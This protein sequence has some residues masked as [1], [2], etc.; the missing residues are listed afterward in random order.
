MVRKTIISALI[1]AGVLLAPL[2][3]DAVGLGK[4]TVSSG[5]GQP[6]RGEMELLAVDRAEEGSLSARLASQDVFREAK[7]ERTAALI[8][9]R[10]NIEQK[11]NGA[12]IIKLTSPQ[13]INDPFL[14]MLIEVNWPSG[15]LLREYTVLL[16]PPGVMAEQQSVMAVET[17]ASK[18]LPDEM[19]KATLPQSEKPRTK[20]ASPASAKAKPAEESGSDS[21]GPVKAGQSL[22]KIAS[23][24]KPEGV[25][26]EQMLVSLYRANQQAFSGNNMNRLK[27]GQ[28][29][30][31]PESSQVAA[32]DKGE[33]EREIRAH[34][35]DWHAYRQKLAGAVETAKPAHEDQ[36][37][38]TATGKITSAVENAPG[39]KEPAKDV[40]KLSKSEN[41]GDKPGKTVATEDAIARDK[42]LQ[43]ANQR[44]AE[45]DKNIKDMQRLLEIRNQSMADL[46]KQA[47]P[48]PP[49]PA[50]AEEKKT[51][52]KPAP[53]K[54]P[55]PAPASVPEQATEQVKP[56]P[57]IVT[58]QPK[59]PETPPPSLL[60]ELLGNPLA[61]IGGALALLLGGLFGARNIIARRKSGKAD[62][63]ARGEAVALQ[64]GNMPEHTL[65]EVSSAL[66]DFTQSGLGGIDTNEVDPIAEAEVY[67]A[68]GRDV[69]AEEILREALARDPQRHEI[70]L[71]LLEIYAGRKD[72][73]SFEALA[74][75]LYAATG[76]SPD[77]DWDKAAE[78]GR[79]LDAANPLYG[80]S[81][82]PPA[83]EAPTSMEETLGVPIDLGETLEAVDASP[84]LDFNLDIASEPLESQMDI[85][86]ESNAASSSSPD[87]ETVEEL[88]PDLDFDLGLDAETPQTEEVA[89]SAEIS[90]ADENLLDFN[91]ETP[92]P[93][94]MLPEAAPLT[95]QE[96][97]PAAEN[98]P[99]DEDEFVLNFD[100]ELPDM[101]PEAEAETVA[102]LAE[103]PVAEEDELGSTAPEVPAATVEMLDFPISELSEST[104]PEMPV[105]AAEE[106]LPAPSD[107]S[108]DETML[109]DLSDLAQDESVAPEATQAPTPEPALPHEEI[110]LTP[111]AMSDEAMLDFDFDIGEETPP[112]I[113]PNLDLSGIDLHLAAPASSDETVAKLNQEDT[114]RFQDAATKMDLAK[115]YMEMGDKEGASEILQE[116]LQEGSDEQQGDAQKLLNE[117]G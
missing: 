46:Q 90:H 21:Y 85:A 102:E 10:F 5:L 79:M 47:K 50:A 65:P 20:S 77:R 83:A 108:F 73:G 71:K 109:L 95:E 92:E 14:D 88:A 13:P 107:T 58:L 87:E 19:V 100:L 11:K 37:R 62:E 9:L 68:Y 3:A 35:A 23:E 38:Q 116:V 84:D 52:T 93:T 67:M 43:D 115:A 113:T 104:A 8:T 114:A 1:G 112:P 17:P 55:E 69:Q 111:P 25:S 26:L 29:L 75:Q 76:G 105:P 40:L 42:A 70:Q 91:L 7:I 34:A 41:T 59:Q 6:F 101:A 97:A 66:T 4:L 64:P 81:E 44:I 33:A 48:T 27:S 110:G 30:R 98:A 57:K 99:D 96:P 36:A 24:I 74:R 45:M 31:L 28:I 53:E 54:A 63:G 80:A 16:D 89:V 72:L 60:N 39:T 103:L 94:E 86:L 2:A 51:E 56:K 61:L 15:R 106:K 12:W 32:L 18:T 117:I 22:S 78:M 49:Q 82:M